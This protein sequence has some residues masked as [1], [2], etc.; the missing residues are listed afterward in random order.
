M[1]KGKKLTLEEQVQIVQ[2]V[3]ANPKSF[4]IYK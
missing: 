4:R 2:Y 1:K 3:Q